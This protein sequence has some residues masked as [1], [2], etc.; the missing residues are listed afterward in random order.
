V[1]QNSFEEIDVATSASGSGKGVNYGWSLM[2]GSR[3]LRGQ[4]DSASLILPTFEYS[5][6]QGCSIT[7]GY[8]YRGSAIPALQGIY[9]YADYCQGWVRSFRYENGT[10]IEGTDW[11][12]LRPGGSIT[13]FGEDA[14]GELYVVDASGGVFKVVPEP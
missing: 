10:A 1:G 9:F 13:S 5:H 12:T 6:R 8:V 7:G 14:A 4:C 2:E 3:C 11:P